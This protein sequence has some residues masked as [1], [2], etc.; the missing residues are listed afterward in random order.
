MSQQNVET[1]RSAFAAVNRGD[2]ETAIGFLDPEVV[3]DATR[4]VFNS[5]T[6]V[7]MQGIRQWIADIDEVWGHFGL[8]VSE[9]IDA[10][11]K[12][13]VIGRLVGR[14]KAS[15]VHVEQPIAGIW[16]LRDG[17]IVRG[18]IGYTD[19]TEALGVAGLKE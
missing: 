16:T 14:G 2:R 6:Y 12:V 13:V 7:G 3:I 5:T 17:H 10:G 4:S 11:D 8:E 15:G 9:L 18:E 1:V 19:R